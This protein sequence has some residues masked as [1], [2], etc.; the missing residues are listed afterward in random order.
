MRILTPIVESG[1]GTGKWFYTTTK[2]GTRKSMC[3]EFLLENDDNEEGIWGQK[4]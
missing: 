2:M 4:R 1:S 3:M